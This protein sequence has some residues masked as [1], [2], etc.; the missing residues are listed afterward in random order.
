MR[1]RD[2]MKAIA[3]IAAAASLTDVSQAQTGLT[4]RSPH[5][6]SGIV[7]VFDFGA[8]G[9][10][11]TDDTAAIQAAIDHALQF[12]LQTVHMPSGV[13]RT[14]DTLHLGYG[15]AFRTVALVGDATFSYAGTTA[16]ARIYPT[17][18]DR[19]A[20]NIQGARGSVIRN[21]AVI[22]KN[23]AFLRERHDQYRNLAEADPAGWLAP[24]LERGIDRFRPYA[25]ITVDAFSGRQH[26]DGY[27]H[28]ELP[29][30]TGVTP[31]VARGFSSDVIIERCYI[32]GF[33]VG[34]AVQPCD[35]DGNGDF[36]KV[37]TSQICRC[38]Y[39]IA[40]G[41]SQSRNVALRDCNYLQL[42]SFINTHAIGR[43]AGALGG[44]IDNV[45]G[46][47]SYQF[48]D[49]RAA[50]THPI[51]VS[52]LYFEAHHR[53]G[54]WSVT[55]SFNHALIFQSC[56][57]N[58]SEEVTQT[59]PAALLECGQQGTVAFKGCAFNQA[60]RM[61]H[62]VRGA[63][64]VGL[65]AC[66]FG[67]ISEYR[68]KDSYASTPEALVRA[69]NYTLGGAFLH[70]ST[71]AGDYAV[72]NGS[73]GLAIATETKRGT[74]QPGHSIVRAAPGLRVVL[75][76]YARQYMDKFGVLWTIKGRARAAALSRPH[77]GRIA[78]FTYTAPDTLSIELTPL[79][80]ADTDT[81]FAA[82]DIIYDDTTGIVMVIVNSAARGPNQALTLH[83]MTGFK[84][85]EGRLQT[86]ADPTRLSGTLWHY[87][88]QAEIGDAVYFGD[89]V[90]GARTI[91]NIATTDGAAD[92][93]ANALKA[94]DVVWHGAG[95]SQ[96]PFFD[97][98]T[99]VTAVDPVKRSGLLSKPARR[100]GRAM[101]TPVALG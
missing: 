59:S 78:S 25:A 95:G 79:A 30:W 62:I 90:E 47:S 50:R 71:L 9:D 65:E 85:A 83:Q 58:L 54:V 73:I 43:G 67:Y 99:T 88:S 60:R 18:I 94:D 41:N 45:S 28:P 39:G 75:H 40:I 36:V 64:F 52:H 8:T 3:G 97:R 12:G 55:A 7:S 5:A 16:G 1:R 74:S 51:T 68:G 11:R 26:A 77:S 37:F 81:K 63:S 14:S 89:V 53:I 34:I 29:K 100:S 56:T 69:L 33:G 48:I 42:H 61:M 27:P 15:D 32:A 13:Y 76:H 46:D 6:R 70:G 31:P 80:L 35:A 4:S 92:G 93:L 57:F 96:Q 84:H 38:V 10:G 98:R 86:L 21:L 66:N 19:P 72:T 22:G 91:E 17:A 23:E 49:V 20:I 101:L 2:V 24:G 44:P 87:S 82:G